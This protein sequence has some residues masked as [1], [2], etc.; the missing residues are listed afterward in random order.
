MLDKIQPFIAIAV[1]IFI[2]L[3]SYLLYQELQ[4]KKEIA[5][6]CNWGTEDF[7][8]VCEK[9]QATE[10]RRIMEIDLNNVTLVK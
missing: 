10:L 8:C 9:E 5:E 7:F 2:L 4:I 3:S 1:F 6:N